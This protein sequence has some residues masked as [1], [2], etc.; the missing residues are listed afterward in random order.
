[1]V[2]PKNINAFNDINKNTVLGIFIDI[3]YMV[4]LCMHSML[5]YIYYFS[6]LCLTLFL[7]HSVLSIQQKNTLFKFFA[8]SI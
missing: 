4:L 7:L 6:S 8:R 2:P 1:M 3:H 5:G